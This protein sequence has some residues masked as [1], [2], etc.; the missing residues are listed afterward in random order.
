MATWDPIWADD[1]YS[2]S[3]LRRLKAKKKVDLFSEF[4]ELNSEN[5][6]VD[7]GCGGGFVSAEIQKR[8]KCKII[9]FDVSEEAIKLARKENAVNNSDYRISSAEKLPL[10]DQSVDAVLCIGVLEHIVDFN[11]ALT[12]I[13]RIL[14]PQGKLV[15]I[16]S[17]LYSLM[18]FDR[19]IKQ[20]FGIW[21]Y[22]YQKN[23]SP[24]QIKHL[25]NNTGF[26]IICKSVFQGFG[27]FNNKNR[28]DT[29]LNRIINSWG[30][31][32]LLLGEKQDEGNNNQYSK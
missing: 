32:I 14:K 22:G 24:R 6:C 9:G 11:D 16:T 1:S 23:W 19:I 2:N 12:E 31:Y 13:Y 8:F 17:N 20:L 27:D 28:I 18:Y 4:L 15:V 3:E 26:H 10:P 30:R 25:L 21:K 7:I 29:L 5:I